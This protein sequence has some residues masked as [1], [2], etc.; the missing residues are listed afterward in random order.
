MLNLSL[1]LF[2]I[3]IRSESVSLHQI[4]LRCGWSHQSAIPVYLLPLSLLQL[5]LVFCPDFRTVP[6]QPV[7][8]AE[9]QQLDLSPELDATPFGRLLFLW[10]S[11]TILRGYRT[12]LRVTDIFVAGTEPTEQV[13]RRF[14]QRFSSSLDYQ[15]ESSTKSAIRLI[16]A[17]LRQFGG[18]FLQI[19]ALK[20]I[21]TVATFLGPLLLDRLISFMNSSK[22]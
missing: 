11:P 13:E 15:Q 16:E 12:P 21:P 2:R 7:T 17:L 22:L 9:S 1:E 14:S 10:F 5:L 3:H 20:L 6:S 19:S 8:G 18:K 4:C